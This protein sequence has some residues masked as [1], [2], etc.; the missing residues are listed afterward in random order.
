MIPKPAILKEMDIY[1]EVE[2]YIYLSKIMFEK[3]SITRTSTE[4]F[5]IDRL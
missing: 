2:D 5:S 1:N 4:V 3:P